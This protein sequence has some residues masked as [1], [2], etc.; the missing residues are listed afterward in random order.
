MWLTLVGFLITLW[1]ISFVIW[2]L[3]KWKRPDDKVHRPP[4][5]PLNSP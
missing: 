5:G 4:P 3:W 1:M 2:S